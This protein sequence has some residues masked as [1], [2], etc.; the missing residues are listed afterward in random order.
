M[1]ESVLLYDLERGVDLQ[2]YAAWA[3]KTIAAVLKA[4]GIVEFRAYRNILGSPQVRSISVWKTL[5]DWA[6]FGESDVW[7]AAE[8]ELRT[9]FASVIR[10]EVWGPSPVAPEPLK[11]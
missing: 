9:Q 5:A 7:K 1:V 10:Y 3:K 4:P 8:A 2:A 11:P 6:N